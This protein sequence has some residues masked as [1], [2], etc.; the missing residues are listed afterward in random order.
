MQ[1]PLRLNGGSESGAANTAEGEL[2]GLSKFTT[3]DTR[4]RC[5]GAV[6]TRR[7]IDLPL[8]ASDIN[9][10]NCLAECSL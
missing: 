8:T 10:R 5:Y 3:T 1:G 6:R 2:A 4:R 9:P 7:Y